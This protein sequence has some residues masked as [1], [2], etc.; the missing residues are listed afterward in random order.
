MWFIAELRC[1]ESISPRPKSNRF[2]VETVV[3]VGPWGS[4]AGSPRLSWRVQLRWGFDPSLGFQAIWDN[5]IPL[6]MGLD[7]PGGRRGGFGYGTQRAAK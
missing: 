4:R 7:L 1:L 2:S 6:L 3:V 5:Y